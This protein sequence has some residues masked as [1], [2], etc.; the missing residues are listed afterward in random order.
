MKTRKYILLAAIFASTIFSAG[1]ANAYGYYHPTPPPPPR[2]APVCPSTNLPIDGN[3][4]W[5]TIA[6]ALIGVIAIKKNKPVL[7]AVFVKK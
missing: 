6:G 7:K 4:V 5:L 3:V 1:K 2:P